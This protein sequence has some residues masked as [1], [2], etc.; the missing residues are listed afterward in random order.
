MKIAPKPKS[1]VDFRDVKEGDIFT[2]D[3]STLTY[4]KTQ[5]MKDAETGGNVNSIS[6][7]TGLGHWWEGSQKVIDWPRATLNFE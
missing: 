2:V 6:M 7:A 5:P 3:G 1:R 4:M